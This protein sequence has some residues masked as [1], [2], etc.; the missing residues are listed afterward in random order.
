MTD[1]IDDGGPAY[2][3]RPPMVRITADDPQSF[4]L[5]R[6]SFDGMSLRDYFAAQAISVLEFSSYYISSQ[7]GGASTAVSTSMVSATETARQAYAIADA[8][9]SARKGKT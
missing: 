3:S 5:V 2:P 8:M 9:L 4:E 1:K 6:T 7:H